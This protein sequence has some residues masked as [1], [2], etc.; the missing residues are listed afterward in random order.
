MQRNIKSKRFEKI[1]KIVN[2]IL[3]NSFIKTK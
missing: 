3:T 1:N 2:N